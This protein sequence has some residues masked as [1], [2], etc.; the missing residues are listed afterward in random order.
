MLFVHHL[1]EEARRVLSE[2]AARV[3]LPKGLPTV[4]ILDSRRRKE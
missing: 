4:A 2:E 3:E 1:I